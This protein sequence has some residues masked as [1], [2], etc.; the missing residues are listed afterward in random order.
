MGGDGTWKTAAIHPNLFA[1][2]VPICG[3][4][5]SDDA[6]VLAG[7]PLWA[8]HGAKDETVPVEDSLQ[9]I[10]AIRK[11]GGKPKLTVIPEAGHG[12]CRSVCSRADLWT[13][14]FKQ[15]RAE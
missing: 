4:G 14:L 8:F 15:H 12:I 9:M 3:S 13:W 2:I 1:A 5:D 11:A 7:I 6:K 10:E